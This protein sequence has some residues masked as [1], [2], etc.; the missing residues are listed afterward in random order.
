[1]PPEPEELI[2]TKLVAIIAQALPAFSVEGT[3]APG[4]AGDVKTCDDSYVNV[5]VDQNEPLLHSKTPLTPTSYAV[6]VAVH[7]TFADDKDGNLFR[8]TC[9][10]VR[11][12][13]NHL[14]GDGCALVTSE[15]WRCDDFV[16]DSTKTDLEESESGEGMV[17][18]YNCTIWGKALA[19]N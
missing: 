19:T 9:R 12:A 18:N 13:L 1:M 16:I 17:K 4:L 15:A 8:D 14:Q 5:K 11:D 3:I 2:E 10:K 6:T 7:C